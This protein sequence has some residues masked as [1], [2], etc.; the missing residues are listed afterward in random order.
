MS[1]E[2]E[3]VEQILPDALAWIDRERPRAGFFA[4]PDRQLAE[5]GIART[6]AEAAR[7]E[8]GF[9]LRNIESYQPDPPDCVAEDVFGR[10]VALEVTELVD[11][12][13]NARAKRD[14]SRFIVPDWDHAK[15]ESHLHER[16][17]A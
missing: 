4:W 2:E 6:F 10:R 17:R 8:P 14:R 11:A 7:S 15:F 1:N 9:P 13:A 3:S 5:R 16:L 12:E